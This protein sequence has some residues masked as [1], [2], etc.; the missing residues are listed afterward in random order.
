M[1]PPI[2]VFTG[3]F[4]FGYLA[5]WAVIYAITKK[6]TKKVN[7]MLKQKQETEKG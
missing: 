6:D 4:L 7:Q 3:I 2:L 1:K 5:I